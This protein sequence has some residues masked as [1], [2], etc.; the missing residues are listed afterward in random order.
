MIQEGGTVKLKCRARGYPS[1]HIV[2]KR[3]EGAEIIIR[4]LNGNKKKGT[5]SHQF[6]CFVILVKAQPYLSSTVYFLNMLNEHLL[7]T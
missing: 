6:L 2:W 5:L 7:T 4:E 3:E 1:P